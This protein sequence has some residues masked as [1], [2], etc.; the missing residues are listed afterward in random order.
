MKLTELEPRWFVLHEG[1]PRVGFTFQCPHCKESRLG[2]AIHE[3]GKTIIPEQEPDAH[4]PGYIW[5]M[6]GTDFHDL[7]LTPSVDASKFGHWHGMLTNGEA[8]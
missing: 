2:V 7:S 4:G 3:A 6:T 8:Q 5:Q 1:G